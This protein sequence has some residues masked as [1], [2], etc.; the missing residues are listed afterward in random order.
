MS[1]VMFSGLATGLDT[2]SIVA[3]LVEL[4]RAPIYRL[5]ARRTGYED[6]ISALGTLKEKLLA[7][8]TAARD[9]D[10]AGEFLSLIST[11]SDENIFTATAGL[12]AA[13]GTY[14][15]TVESLATARKMAS[16]GYDSPMA[17]VGSGSFTYTV[18]GRT[19]TLTLADGTTLEGLRDAINAGAEGI[20]A[21]IINDGSSDGGYRLVVSAQETGTA[22]DF[23][24][25][26]S[27]MAGS[28]ALA[29]TDLSLAAD[30]RLTIDGLAVTASSNNPSDVISGL[31]LDLKAA[32]STATLTVERDD[33][34]IAD[35]VKV[36]VDAY[37]DLAEFSTAQ[38]ASESPLYGDSTLRMVRGRI[39]AL[40]TNSQGDGAVSMFAQIGVSRTREGTLEWNEE[41]FKTALGE[42]IGAV[43]DFFIQADGVTG[44]GYLIDQAVSDMTDSAEGMFK[45]S[46][47]SLNSRIRTADTRIERYESS[48]EAYRANLERRF[49][50]MES[51]VAQLQAQGNYLNGIL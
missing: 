34:A 45:I 19:E 18:G 39:D 32:G 7:L 14:N 30:A 50:A 38:R 43:R 40:F 46:I 10:T 2:A 20:S 31:T 16:Q 25:D 27:G 11:S 37:N 15:I 29:F 41:A 17:A 22:G 36:L 3:Q 49:I 51:M 13:P 21:T 23:S 8:Q 48:I 5:Q 44:K 28:S 24:L 47:D 33:Q 35:K 6:K 26:L 42:D 9:L 4:R 1:S 12:D